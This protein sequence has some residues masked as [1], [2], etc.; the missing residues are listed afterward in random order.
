MKKCPFCAEEIKEEAIKC[1]H[2]G[3]SLVAISSNKESELPKTIIVKNQEGAFLK[4]LNGGCI[5]IIVIICLI[6]GIMF[7]SSLMN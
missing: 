4:T 6:I 5:V 1:R 7:M 2:C 3:S